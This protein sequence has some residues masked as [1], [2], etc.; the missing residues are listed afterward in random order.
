MSWNEW[1]KC[2]KTSEDGE[3][4]EFMYGKELTIRI[5]IDT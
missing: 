1:N 3:I 5:S 4:Y 2:L